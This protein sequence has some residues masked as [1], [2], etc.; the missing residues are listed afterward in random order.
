MSRTSGYLYAQYALGNPLFPQASRKLADTKSWILYYSKRIYQTGTGEWN[1]SV[2]QSYS[3]AGWLNLYDLAADVEVRNAAR[4][5]LDYYTAES[6]L[7]TFYGITS[8]AEMRGSSSTS[9]VSGYDYLSW[10]WFG[11]SPK[12]QTASSFWTPKEYSQSV[13]A[14]VSTYRPNPIAVSLAFKTDFFAGLLPK[15]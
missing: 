15:L 7:H 10:M 11:N 5:V 8:G 3:I 4:A 2:Y 12:D 1:S 13:H 9:T 14:A 6:A